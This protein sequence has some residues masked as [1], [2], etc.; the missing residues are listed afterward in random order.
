MYWSYYPHRLTD[1]V[2]PVCGIFCKLYSFRVFCRHLIRHQNNCLS[3][4]KNSS[5]LVCLLMQRGSLSIKTVIEKE[6]NLYVC[7]TK[8]S[9]K[10]AFIKTIWNIPEVLLP[11]FVY[12]LGYESKDKG[13]MG[14][15]FLSSCV[16]IKQ[17][18]WFPLERNSTT[19]T[20]F[21][22]FSLSDWLLS[23]LTINYIEVWANTLKVY[24]NCPK[25]SVLKFTLF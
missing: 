20:K 13:R 5:I 6:K 11:A 25:H 16:V 3:Y 14:G 2:S 8:R 9:K 18:Y 21:L 10:I 15:G 4:R 7:H 22:V 1:L 17:L 24:F 23:I 12:Y 19:Q